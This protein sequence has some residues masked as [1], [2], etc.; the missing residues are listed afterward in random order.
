MGRGWNA[1]KAR[2]YRRSSK[3][4][5]TSRKRSGPRRTRSEPRVVCGRKAG[6]GTGSVKETASNGGI[7]WWCEMKMFP[8]F[9]ALFPVCSQSGATNS[10]CSQCSWSACHDPYGRGVLLIAICSSTRNTGNIRSR[11]KSHDLGSAHARNRRGTLGTDQPEAEICANQRAASPFDQHTRQAFR[12][13][14]MMFPDDARQ[15]MG[16]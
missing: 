10:L 5:S 16:G 11:L 13:D 4:A 7:G 6:C 3:D 1:N 14:R 15:E 2:Q 8:G 12:T 9:P